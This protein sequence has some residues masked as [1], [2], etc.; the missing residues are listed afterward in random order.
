[1][2]KNNNT[3]KLILKI[4]LFVVIF[5]ILAGIYA[6]FSGHQENPEDRNYISFKDAHINDVVIKMHELE[7][8]IE[9][10]QFPTDDDFTT[11]FNYNDSSLKINDFQLRL[12]FVDFRKNNL[13]KRLSDSELIQF[14]SIFDFLLCNDIKPLRYYYNSEQISF[15]Y[16][17]YYDMYH[18]WC[19]DD[20]LERYLTFREDW[21]N[22]DYEIFK[23]LSDTNG[24]ILYTFKSSEI[25]GDKDIHYQRR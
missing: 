25:W 24:L 7:N 21:R 15:K 22:H 19:Y 18:T 4:L 17:D 8:L 6:I 12:S 9:K 13:F 5:Y 16:K 20:H 1:M 14:I 2:K 10:A 11:M 3:F 23:I